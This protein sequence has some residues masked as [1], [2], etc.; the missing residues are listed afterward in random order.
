[1]RKGILF[2]FCLVAISLQAQYQYDETVFIPLQEDELNKWKIE[3]QT[4][5]EDGI[6]STR[7]I[8]SSEN[9]AN[10]SK[11]LNIKFHD[12]N[13]LH[14]STAMEAMQREQ[15]SS[16]RVLCNVLNQNIN[17]L[18]YERAFP[19]GEHELVRMIMTKKGLHRISYVKRGPFD[20]EERNYWVER[21][22]SSIVGK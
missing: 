2:I 16:P 18:T 21:L 22:M 1:M 10:W 5:T 15:T 9:T 11:L 3:H 17:D 13:T 14:A 12:R 7:Y 4:T 8:P 19:T 20:Q 6:S